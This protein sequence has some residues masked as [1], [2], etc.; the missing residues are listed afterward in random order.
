MSLTFSAHSDGSDGSLSVASL[1][2]NISMSITSS[3]SSCSSGRSLIRTMQ[4]VEDFL[5]PD[6]MA[7][8]AGDD[9]AGVADCVGQ[10]LVFGWCWCWPRT[11][12]CRL[13][14]EYYWGGLE[15]M[16]VDTGRRAEVESPACESE[17]ENRLMVPAQ[18]RLCSG[19]SRSPAVSATDLGV[20]GGHHRHG[21][22]RAAER[23]K[24]R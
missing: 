22:A 5:R 11:S 21:G 20:M 23:Q 3:G 4:G 13:V 2:A 9:G 12:A 15:R 14:E 10:I 24:T 17:G 1:S 16:V 18:D 19:A 6:M 8:A 7:A